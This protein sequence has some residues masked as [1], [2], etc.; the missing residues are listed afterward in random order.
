MPVQEK[1]VQR[2]TKKKKKIYP[3][4]FL[5]TVQKQ[6]K[7]RMVF[8]INGVETIRC[9]QQKR[10]FWPKSHILHKPE[11][12][13]IYMQNYKTFRRKCSRGSSWLRVT[14][15]S[16]LTPKSHSIKENID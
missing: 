12:K 5:T 9:P 15:F 4:D 11:L 13:M 1:N 3:T 2:E 14:E 16:C 6:F 10:A 7:G 8:S